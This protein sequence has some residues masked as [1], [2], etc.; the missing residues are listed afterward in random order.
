MPLW[1][2]TR[3]GNVQVAKRTHLS[4][5]PDQCEDLGNLFLVGTW[6]TWSFPLSTVQ[7]KA[8]VVVHRNPCRWTM[9][10]K[11][12]GT[13]DNE[14]NN[15]TSVKEKHTYSRFLV[16]PCRLA[17][18]WPNIAKRVKWTSFTALLTWLR[19]RAD[20]VSLW[21]NRCQKS[22]NAVFFVFNF[23]KWPC[24]KKRHFPPK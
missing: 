22:K 18:F 10:M 24:K 7:C 8:P 14:N 21:R 15:T 2:E 12:V 11:I 13:K 23:P 3:S 4:W 17:M 9:V 5:V 20:C 1:R 16:W 19:A 6:W